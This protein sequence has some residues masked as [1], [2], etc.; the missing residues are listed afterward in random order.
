MTD[1]VP[2][3]IL[4]ALVAIQ[5]WGRAMTDGPT[6]TAR[7]RIEATVVVVLSLAALGLNG[8]GALSASTNAWNWT[9]VSVDQDPSRVWDWRNA[10]FLAPW[11]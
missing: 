2:W 9:P 5:G 8:V 4:A 7:F 3:L 1:A 10:Q 11:R 6:N